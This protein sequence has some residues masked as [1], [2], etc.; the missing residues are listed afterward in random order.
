MSC[1]VTTKSDGIWGRLQPCL[2]CRPWP[3]DSAILVE[4]R[5]M[6]GG[7]RLVREGHRDGVAVHG[8]GTPRA[9]ADWVPVPPPQTCDLRPVAALPVLHWGQASHTPSTGHA[10]RTRREH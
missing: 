2:R 7:L 9:G 8:V 1:D 10:S 6:E 5:D 3:H 4:T